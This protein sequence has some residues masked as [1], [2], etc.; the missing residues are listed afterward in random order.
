MQERCRPSG[1]SISGAVM[2][3]DPSV[4]WAQVFSSSSADH[5]ELPGALGHIL[6][7]RKQ[8]NRTEKEAE[9][10]A[11]TTYLYL[12]DLREPEVLSTISI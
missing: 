12:L 3:V 1:S 9:L 6:R 11:H 5:K 10:S 8:L 4:V 2:R 7:D